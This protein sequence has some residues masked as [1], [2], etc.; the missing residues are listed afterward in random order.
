MTR[1]WFM[2][3]EYWPSWMQNPFYVYAKVQF[4]GTWGKAASIKTAQYLK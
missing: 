1:I 2:P 4:T 3:D